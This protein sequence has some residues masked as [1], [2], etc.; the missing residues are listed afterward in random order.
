[1]CDL[2]RTLDATVRV[3]TRQ[4]AS[5]AEIWPLQG[6]CVLEM[7]SG[8]GKTVSL[9]SLIVSYQQVCIHSHIFVLRLHV[10]PKVLSSQTEADLLLTYSPRNRKGTRRAEAAHGVSYLSRRDPRREGQGR[11][12]HRLGTHQSQEL[13]H[14]PGR[15]KREKGQGRR[16]S[17]SR[18]H[19]YFGMREGTGGSRIG[20]AV[21]LA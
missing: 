8:T 17:V 3:F 2:K 5:F 13:V 12:V 9:L 10:S 6:H 15:F 14:P 20:P 4:L 16:C 18:P 21:R 11:S 19:K 1:M 7:P